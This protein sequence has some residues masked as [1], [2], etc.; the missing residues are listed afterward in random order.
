MGNTVVK[1]PD[2]PM[3]PAQ[4]TELKNTAKI[5]EM[6]KGADVLV[7]RN[8]ET[9]AYLINPDHYKPTYLSWRKVELQSR[10]LP[11]PLCSL[12]PLR[13]KFFGVIGERCKCDR[14]EEISCFKVRQGFSFLK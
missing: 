11:L 8:G 9:V 13:L 12:R 3:K 6:A 1:D 10:L 5:A 7:T 2:F 14:V 4:V